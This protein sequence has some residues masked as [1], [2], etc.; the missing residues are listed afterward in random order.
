MKTKHLQHAVNAAFWLAA[1]A[2]AAVATFLAVLLYVDWA[3][4]PGPEPAVQYVIAQ[5]AKLASGLSL[6]TIS[7]GVARAKLKEYC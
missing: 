3:F 4:L 5:H 2:L 7:L 1:L 6:L